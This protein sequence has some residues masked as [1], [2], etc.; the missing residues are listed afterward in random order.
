MKL[1]NPTKTV[2]IAISIIEYSFLGDPL[3]PLY[4]YAILKVFLSMN[5]NIS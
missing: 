3:L 5:S 1:P 4:P 2:E